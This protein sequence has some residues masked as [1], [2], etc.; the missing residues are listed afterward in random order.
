MK[1]RVVKIPIYGGE[2]IMYLVDDWDYMNK[3]YSKESP[4]T[5]RTCGVTFT[6][7]TTAGYSQYIVAFRTRPSN[8]VISHEVTHIVNLLFR[9]RGIILD[10]DNDEPQAYFTDWVFE[11]I[12]NFFKIKEKK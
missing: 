1:K 10:V 7:Y 11:Q 2:L 6:N 4:M 9:D 5:N 12:E 8:S 3:K